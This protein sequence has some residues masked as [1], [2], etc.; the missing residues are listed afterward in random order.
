M[1]ARRALTR[2]DAHAG[3]MQ[4][5]RAVGAWGYRAQSTVA[6]AAA[7]PAACSNSQVAKEPLHH[8]TKEPYYDITIKWP[9]NLINEPYYPYKRALLSI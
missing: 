6:R 9:T 7:L 8:E 4:A 5:A 1:S 3:A 2:K